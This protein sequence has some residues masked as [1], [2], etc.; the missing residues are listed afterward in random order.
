M[1]VTWSLFDLGNTVIKLAYERVLES[2]RKESSVTRDQIVELFEQPGS[3]RDLERGAINI[4]EFYDFLCDR[5]A[6]ADRDA[7]D[8]EIGIIN[9]FRVGLHHGFGNAELL[10]PRA[11]FGGPRGGDDLFRQSLFA[12][13]ARDRA[14]DQPEADQRDPFEWRRGVHW[15]AT[16]SRK[17]S[18]TRRLA[19]SVPMVMRSACGRR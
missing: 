10:D 2:L 16:K 17:P 19:S 15:R 7:Q 6:G 14:A 9:R 4:G 18:T 5:A 8:D 12:R 3:Y 13:G 1:A 11:G